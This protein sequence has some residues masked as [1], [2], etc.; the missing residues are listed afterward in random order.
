[1]S[2]LAGH[3]LF[4]VFSFHS[5]TRLVFGVG[6]RER[7]GEEAA[8]YGKKAL[9]VS[10]AFLRDRAEELG[11]YMGDKGIETDIYAEVR[12]EP[13]VDTL[14][15]AAS[16]AMDVEPDIVVGIGGGSTMDTAKVVSASLRNDMSI[17]D[18]VGVDKVPNKGVPLILLPTTA[19]TGS[20]VN[21]TAML[22]IDGLK[23]WIMSGNITADLAIVDPELTVTC[24]PR[25]TAY[26]GMDTLAHAIEGYISLYGGILT[27]ALALEVA[28]LVNKYLVKAYYNGR[29]IEARYAMS[30]AATMAGLVLCGTTA[31][32]GHSIAYTL[33][34]YNVPHAL[35]T[36]IALPYTIMIN[37][38]VIP[39]KIARL[40]EALGIR[41]GSTRERA[42]STV[43]RIRELLSE[44][45][46][47]LALKDL[48]VPKEDLEM[49]AKELIEKY[50]R[51]NNPRVLTYEHALKLYE[52][53]WDG[54]D[55]LC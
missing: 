27:D 12:R 51:E 50:P 55:T 11:R 26:T 40:G 25:I 14:K 2:K 23:K 22:T 13:T 42:I 24:P 9:I 39:D 52:V 6:S 54:R 35:G 32:Y 41:E 53:M 10:D 31:V 48:G 3:P 45:E 8:K 44:L 46:I 20:E 16:Y 21:R 15:D 7:I 19:G 29:D 4:R 49:L 28:Y 43:S 30:F 38:P 1:M 17:E 34:R 47:P 37:L 33:V 36:A 18:M 5:P